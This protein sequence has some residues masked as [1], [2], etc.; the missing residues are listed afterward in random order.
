M[1]LYEINRTKLRMNDCANQI[2]LFNVRINQIQ[3]IISN[4]DGRFDDNIRK[5]NSKVSD[6]VNDFADGMKGKANISS[7]A[8]AMDSNRQLYPYNDHDLS[9][10]KY[11]LSEEIQR[12]QN[13]QSSLNADL[14]QLKYT[15][16]TL[17][18]QEENK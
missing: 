18:K 14:S 1:S 5:V 8:T 3:N 10:C 7:I 13:Q 17:K 9:S 11:N 16:A 6:C 12:N 4:I 2:K 15:L